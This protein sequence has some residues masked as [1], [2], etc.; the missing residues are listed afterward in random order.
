MGLGNGCAETARWPAL[1]NRQ[2]RANL[3]FRF[4]PA[5]ATLMADAK[6]SARRGGDT[7][8]NLQPR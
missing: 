1:A 7:G 2:M 6:G 3:W 4:A 8:G 5:F